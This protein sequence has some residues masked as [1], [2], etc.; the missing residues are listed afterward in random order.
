VKEGRLVLP[1]GASY[2]YLQLPDSDRM[3]LPL[4]RKIRELVAGGARVIGGKRPKGTPGLTDFPRGDAEVEKIAAELWDTNRAGS[5]Q[6]LA[7][8]FTR[9]ALKPDFEGADL[10]YIHRRVGEVDIYFVSHQ[11][12]RP[13][14][15]TCTFRVSGR[16]PELWD[17]ETG[18]VRELPEFEEK[19]GRISVPLRFEP[20]QSWFVVFRKEVRGRMPEVGKKNWP[21]YRPLQEI[22]GPWQV[23][24]DPKW[25]GPKEEVTFGQLTDW[26]K[27]PDA[28]IHYYS[29]TATYSCK[30]QIS[31]LRSQIFL[32]LG[33]VEVMA[34]VRLNGRDCGIAW[35][36]PYLVDI[37][38]AARTGENSLEV[39][40]V[41]LW[42]NRL[43]G[44]EQL[45][46]DGNWKDFETLREWPEWFRKGE[47]RPSGRYTFT[48][49]RHYKK[50]SPLV[51]SGLLGPVTVCVGEKQP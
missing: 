35:K 9:D 51:P 47:P 21:E 13:R 3:T 22:G 20:M 48:T 39:A 38:G 31:D 36:P 32:D 30:F 15:A 37:S 18:A 11:E 14:D 17:P 4:A 24:F 16:L 44:D 42:I 28:R 27:N 1:S 33:A 12:N 46:L 8:I 7:E 2:R 45:P 25:G 40:A 19:D 29:G 6:Q 26:S 43:I 49:C 50:D 23:S 41:N 5:G 10:H 34:R